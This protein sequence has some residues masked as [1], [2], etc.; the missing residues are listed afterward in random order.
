MTLADS[1]TNR[2]HRQH[3]GMLLVMLALL[4]GTG[5]SSTSISE[6]DARLPPA[7]VSIATSKE[8]ASEGLA[9]EKSASEASTSEEQ[10][11]P[12]AAFEED[13][14]YQLLVAEVAGHRR[15]YQQALQ[16]YVAVT[17][18]TRDP[19]VAARATQLALY[20]QDLDTALETA[21]IW[22]T[23][24][25]AHFDILNFERLVRHSTSP[26]QKQSLLE[27]LSKV[28]AQQPEQPDLLFLKAALLAQTGAVEQSLA[29]AGQLL[30][31]SDQNRLFILQVSNLQHL[32]RQEEARSLLETALQIRP[33]DSWLLLT[34]ARL[35]HGEGEL[36]AAREQYL[37]A[38]EGT[39]NDGDILL[40][41]ALLAIEEA[42]DEV[43][44]RH[45]E[46]LLRWEQRQ[47]EAHYY[48]GV[49]AERQS[50]PAT[51]IAAYKQVRQ[52]RVFP[53]AQARIATLLAEDN[54]LP[55]AR[56][57]LAQI[58]KAHPKLYIRMTILEAQL[59]ATYDLEQEVF[60]LLDRA[61]EK[62]SGQVP[63]Q[64]EL[65]YIR[66]M[67]GERFGH[68]DILE[69]NLRQLLALDPTHAEALNAL[70]YTLTEQTDRHAE[71]LLLIEQALALKPEEA[72]FID[73]LGW[74]QYRL[75]NYDAALQHLRRAL[76]LFPNDEIAAH[77]GEVLWTIGAQTEAKTIWDRAL[78]MSPESEIL[79]DVI[80]RFQGP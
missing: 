63:Q 57:H 69:T 16:H 66:A 27:G 7:K 51:A 62:T 48:L 23:T 33:K 34:L 17:L 45:L 5:C 29:L 18:A 64:I 4:S 79:R 35:L 56:A 1:K 65:L 80:Q 42:Q 60:R 75:Q 47:E 67:L 55:A 52:S 72:A 20:M 2:M 77:L 36:D 25:P 32:G 14:L 24:D 54:Q 74:V 44:K 71:A 46:R 40:A 10:T 12:L 76:A 28:L 78:E 9:S 70:G 37:L 6:S 49:I 73:S 61:L 22:A 53:L 21:M 19:G 58:A 13:V 15:H 26:S 11:Y 31:A 8:S 43:A 38:L 30:E 59:L 50:D 68:L 39:D 41:L 3:Y